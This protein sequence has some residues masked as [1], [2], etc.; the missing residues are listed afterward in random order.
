MHS[1]V[2]GIDYSSFYDFSFGFY[3]FSDS[4]G[5]FVFSFYSD[6]CVRKIYFDQFYPRTH[7]FLNNLLQLFFLLKRE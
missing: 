3:N 1:C 7:L 2:R 5:F 4:L 6:I